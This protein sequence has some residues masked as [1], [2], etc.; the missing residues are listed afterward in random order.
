VQDLE[1]SHEQFRRRTNM[2]VAKVGYSGSVL[3]LEPAEPGATMGVERAADLAEI[4]FPGF[5]DQDAIEPV[6]RACKRHTPR[7][8]LGDLRPIA[9]PNVVGHRP[10]I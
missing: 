10:S 6:M 3:G 9:G 8:K 5:G 7:Y 2:D 1:P 4:L